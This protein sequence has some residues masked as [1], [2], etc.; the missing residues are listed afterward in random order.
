MDSKITKIRKKSEVLSRIIKILLG[1][2]SVFFIIELIYTVF[3]IFLPSS[4]LT[5]LKLNSG[6]YIENS[7]LYINIAS[8]VDNNIIHSFDT[9][10]ANPKPAL[11]INLF[12]ALI[13]TG[14]LVAIFY[15]TNQIFHSIN[16]DHTPFTIE[17]AKRIKII[18]I[19]LLIIATVP[20]LLQLLLYYLIYLEPGSYTIGSN[21]A[22]IL[23]SLVFMCLSY[24]FS[25]GCDLQ[26][27]VDETL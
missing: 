18:A 2:T 24:I 26:Q 9:L 22:L 10:A 19:L 27:E 1:L 23:F 15:L 6:Y 4:D 17:N 3:T 8:S 11:L 21:F 7:S 12:V 16:T 13:I 20:I 25:Y 5:V 14:L